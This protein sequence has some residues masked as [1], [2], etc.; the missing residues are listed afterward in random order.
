MALG[1]SGS[2]H[3]LNE[4]SV[5]IRPDP[6]FAR[7]EFLYQA[8][9]KA[10]EDSA[11]TTRTRSLYEELDRINGNDESGL[12]RIDRWRER[13]EDLAA[14]TQLVHTVYYRHPSAID[15]IADHLVRNTEDLIAAHKQAG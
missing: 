8:L 4:V 11:V 14:D 6:K 2:P 5:L 3:R 15:Q 9:A 10:A 12:W 7:G 13:I 1:M